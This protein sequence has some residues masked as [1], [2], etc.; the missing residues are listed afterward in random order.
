[1]KKGI[2]LTLFTILLSSQAF[3]NA[4]DIARSACVGLGGEQRSGSILGTAS[5]GWELLSS[6]RQ[7]EVTE[8]KMICA[9]F[10]CKDG[11]KTIPGR[12]SSASD[13]QTGCQSRAKLDA[14]IS[15]RGEGSGD[16]K[17]DGGGSGGGGAGIDVRVSGGTSPGFKIKWK[18]FYYSRSCFKFNNDG[19]PIRLKRRCR[20]KGEISVSGGVSTDGGKRRGGGDIIVD[21]H[22]EVPGLGECERARLACEGSVRRG[23]YYYYRRGGR[24]FKCTS[25]NDL[26]TCIQIPRSAYYRIYGGGDCDGNCGSVYRRRDSIGSQIGSAALGIG[27]GGGALL[28]PI[29]NYFGQKNV[30]NGMVQMNQD[31]AAALQ[32]MQER[33]IAGQSHYRNTFFGVDGYIERNEI[34]DDGTYSQVPECNYPGALGMQGDGMGGIG[35]PLLGAGYQMNYLGGMLG[36]YGAYGAQAYGIPPALAGLGGMGGLNGLNF[37]LGLNGLGGLGGL[38]GLNNFGG[39]GSLGVYGGLGGLGT[40]GGLGNLG[41]YGGLGNLGGYGGLGGLGGYGGMAPWGNGG[42]YWNNAGGWAQAQQ[43][44]ALSNQSF[45]QG[46]QLSQLAWRDQAI[47]AQQG[48]MGAGMAGMWGAGM[49]GLGGFGG[50][51]FSPMNLGAQMGGQFRFGLGGMGGLGGWGWP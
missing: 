3:G 7:K 22:G 37:Q 24:Y 46:Q 11:K 45:V 35:H 34:I 44:L 9:Y 33:C 23:R 20:N 27:V 18:G 29:L 19:E 17:S 16:D 30:I 28:S 42:S 40:Y 49:G 25:P 26:N 38:G 36:Q 12:S 47:R 2:L 48:M 13:L 10:Q 15:G 1:M 6:D 8:G 14:E 50:A 21:G 43:S 41:G 39:L 5:P 4:H 31:N 51:A 32:A